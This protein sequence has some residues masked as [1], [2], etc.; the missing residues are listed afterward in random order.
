MSAPSR[1]LD[2]LRGVVPKKNPRRARTSLDDAFLFRAFERARAAADAAMSS[3]QAAGASAAQ[4]K[5]ALDTVGDGMRLLASRVRDARGQTS[6]ARE[7]LDQ[8]RIVA[9]NA[10]L[11]GARLGDPLG[12]PLSL[13]AEEVRTHLA[14]SLAALEDHATVQ[15]QLDRDYEKLKEQLDVAQA[16]SAELARE[17][18]SAQATQRD[19][20]TSLTEVGDRIKDASE[21]DPETARAVAEAAEH[22][23]ALAASLSALSSKPHRASLLGALGP[24]LGPLFKLLREVYRAGVDGEPP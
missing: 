9:L 5:N 16:R 12:K 11:E 15:A 13:V 17:L 8:I 22:A 4:Q 19:A 18:L 23:R 24:S 21:T 2:L 3:T 1:L 10:G 14:R 6:Q 20:V 7:S